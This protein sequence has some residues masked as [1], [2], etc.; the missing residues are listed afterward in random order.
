MRRMFSK[1]QLKEMI[2]E[3]FTTPEEVAEMLESDKSIDEQIVVDESAKTASFPEH[4]VP[5]KAWDGSV[6][7]YIFF[8]YVNKVL[9][10]ETGATISSSSIELDTDSGKI[11]INDHS[12][13]APDISEVLYIYLSDIDSINTTIRFNSYAVLNPT[14]KIYYHPITIYNNTLG[15]VSFVIL[16]NDPTAYTKVSLISFLEN[17]SFTRISPLS[18]CFKKSSGVSPLVV[19]AAFKE[20]G[21]F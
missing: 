19:S 10:D 15:S 3:N 8:D 11:Y 18:G 4:V 9:V 2:D 5:L 7:G 21:V 6:N 13:D 14:K 20:E 17:T 12:G 1:N 16:N